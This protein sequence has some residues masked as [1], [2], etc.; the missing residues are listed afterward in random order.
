MPQ[1]NALVGPSYQLSSV[2]ADCESSICCWREKIES[3]QGDNDYVLR[4]TAGTEI[5]I[6]GLPPVGHRGA[7]ELNGHLF[8]VVGETLY[9]YMGQTQIAAYPGVLG[10]DPVAMAASFST[11]MIVA[12]GQLFRLSGGTLTNLG[13][14]FVPVGVSFISNYFVCG[15]TNASQGRWSEDDGATWPE[16]LVFTVEDNANALVGQAAVNGQLYLIGN[17]TTKP[18]YVGSNPNNVFQAVDN[19]LIPAGTFSAASVVEQDGQIYMLSQMAGGKKGVYR[20]SGYSLE[21]VSNYFVDDAIEAMDTITDAVGQPYEL[22]GHGFYRITFPTEQRTFELHID[23]MEWSEVPWWNPA[24]SQYEAHRAQ[25][26]VSHL[27]NVLCG[28]RGNGLVYRMSFD[29][30]HDAGFQI[31]WERTAPYVVNGRKPVGFGA[32]FLGMETGV[33][34]VTPLWL[35]D[36]RLQ[37]TDFATALAAAVSG[38]TVTA[39]QALVIQAIY[40]Y[41]PYTPLDPYPDKDTMASLGFYVWGR[42]PVIT[43][44]LSD[45]FGK[46][47]RSAGSR[48]IGRSGE[49]QVQVHWDGLG[50]STGR[51]FRVWGDDPVPYNIVSAELENTR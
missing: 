21:K 44:E 36:H 27:G 23:N 39:D 43:L 50:S 29:I 40:D 47:F 38:A 34:L 19:V 10:T 42:D 13:V 32:L 28:D 33:G 11:L 4:K 17:R 15:T 9:D 37:P 30:A 35:N 22:A 14:T 41:T 24:T 5:Y 7:F 25:W 2:R 8:M 45:D 6:S 1:F 3:G 26:I 18:F 16:D 31:R 51:V 12:N 48:S 49:A 20:I 46:T